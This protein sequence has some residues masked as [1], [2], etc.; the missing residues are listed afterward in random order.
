MMIAFNTTSSLVPLIES[1][2]SSESISIRV[3]GSSF[4]FLSFAFLFWKKKYVTGKKAVSPGLIPPPSIHV[5]LCT[6]YTY[7]NTYVPRFSSPGFLGPSRCLF[8][9]PGLTSSTKCGVCVCAC[10]YT[11]IHTQTPPP[12]SKIENTQI[13]HLYIS[14]PS[15]INNP[16]HQ[17]TSALHRLVEPPHPRPPTRMNKLRIHKRMCT[18]YSDCV[19]DMYG[20]VKTPVEF[21]H[22]H[23]LTHRTLV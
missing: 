8:P 6:L 3:L 9:T 23:T 18:P 2:C 13:Q 12:P 15:V 19:A 10:V 16:P 7:S 14:G 21:T 5:H 11:H 1:L 4:T 17:E 20:D 22:L